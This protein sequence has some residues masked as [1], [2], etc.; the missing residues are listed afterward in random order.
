VT[1]FDV[2]RFA[3]ETPK[4]SAIPMP[5]I[6]TRRIHSTPSVPSIFRPFASVE[7]TEMT[8]HQLRGLL[9]GNERKILQGR[10]APFQI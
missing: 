3:T 9:R 10:F 7:S 6:Q 1:I 2:S 8:V 5:E 4:S